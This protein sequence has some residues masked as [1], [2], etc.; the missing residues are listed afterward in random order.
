MSGGSSEPPL[1]FARKADE[2]FG[3]KLS[4]APD[5][6]TGPIRAGGQ[7]RQADRGDHGPRIAP[8]PDT[9]FA[10]TIAYGGS[11]GRRPG[12]ANAPTPSGSAAGR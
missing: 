11:R 2:R 8:N 7:A 5:V 1:S 6:T 4:V 9:R 3:S 10:L 12:S